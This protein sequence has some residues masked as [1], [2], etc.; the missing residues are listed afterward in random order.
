MP[1]TWLILGRSLLIF[2][3]FLLGSLARPQ[4]PPQAPIQ[5]P[6]D[7]IIARVNGEAILLSQLKQAAFDQDVPLADLTSAGLQGGGYRRAMTEIVDEALLVQKANAEEIKVNEMEIAREVDEMIATVRAQMGS[8]AK[9]EKFLS[10]HY[11][12]LNSLRKMMSERERRRT[13]QMQLIVRRV[14]VDAGA[15][16]KF[17]AERRAEKLPQE[18]VNLAQIL[19]RCQPADRRTEVGK[20]IYRKALGIAREV[21]ANP[22]EFA[23]YVRQYSDDSAGRG[24]GGALGWLDPESLRPSLRDQVKTMASGDISSPIETEDGYHILLLIS[25]HTTRDLLFARRFAEEREKLITQLRRD[26][27]IHLYGL[28]G[29][30]LE[31]AAD[32]RS[33]APSLKAE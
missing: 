4:A 13:I 3:L 23:K 33:A 32:S 5:A 30:P 29:K 20:A 14:S 18:E 12:D 19:I 6:S 26:A 10:E 2:M 11:L 16:E 7:A 1:R 17:A 28:N 24:H 27:S 9:L 15:I 22:G 8:Q 25:R 21:G 31:D